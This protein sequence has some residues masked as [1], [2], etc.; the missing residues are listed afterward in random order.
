MLNRVLTLAVLIALAYFSY[1][2]VVP[3][4]RGEFAAG[5]DLGTPH[6]DARA[7][8]CVGSAVEANATLT[9]SARRFKSPPVDRDSW[10]AAVWEIE[11]EIQSAA[12][13]C[14]CVS[15]ACL[16]ANQALDEIRLALASLDRVVQGDAAG[17][18]NPAR[19]QERIQALLEEARRAVER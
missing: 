17:F 15:E 5:A 8:E 18:S 16:K 19:D 1:T 6:P 13:A 2:R 3:W 14:I 10:S 7:G 9:E 11:R 12:A 4:L